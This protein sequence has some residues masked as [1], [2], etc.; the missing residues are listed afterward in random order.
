MKSVLVIDDSKTIREYLKLILETSGY[1]VIEA[2]NG[3]EGYELF[4]KE[5]PDIV[6]TD[7]FMPEMDGIEF[8]QK[9][10]LEAPSIKIIAISDGGRVGES[11][12][13]KICELLGAYKCMVKPIK[14][15]LLLEALKV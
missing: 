12:Y 10:H 5:N 13:L 8:I 6:I 15:D 9:L 1:S 7:I 11:P 4:T 2:I 3:K 14:K